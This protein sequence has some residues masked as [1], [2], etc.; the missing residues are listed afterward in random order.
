MI[1]EI[2]PSPI[3]RFTI[4][5]PNASIRDATI[6]GERL[7]HHRPVNV[8]RYKRPA[9]D[10]GAAVVFI[11]NGRFCIYIP[12][13]GTTPYRARGGIENLRLIH[14]LLRRSMPGVTE[15]RALRAP[16]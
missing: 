14:E 6:V 9:G 3:H 7:A 1:S 2:S 15:V 16:G 12:E 10:E 13:F 5:A 4:S 8:I 11:F